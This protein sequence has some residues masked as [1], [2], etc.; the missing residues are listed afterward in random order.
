MQLL[1]TCSITGL[2]TPLLMLLG[3]LLKNL[4]CIF[5]LFPLRTRELYRR[6]LM[7]GSCETIVIVSLGQ[8]IQAS[9]ILYGHLYFENQ[10]SLLFSLYILES[11]SISYFLFCFTTSQSYPSHVLTI[12]SYTSFPFNMLLW[13]YLFYF[14]LVKSK[15]SSNTIAH[16]RNLHPPCVLHIGHL[17]CYPHLRT[18]T[19]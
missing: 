18:I 6:V 17:L 11:C 13:E 7:Y 5:L 4:N 16:Y 8:H 10:I 3:N 19:S 12:Q 15:Y 14:C 2:I 9:F 1:L